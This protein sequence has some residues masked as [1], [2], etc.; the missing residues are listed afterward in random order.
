MKIDKKFLFFPA[1]HT[2]PHVANVATNGIAYN[3]LVALPTGKVW[4]LAGTYDNS[5]EMSQIYELDCGDNVENCATA[6]WVLNES[7]SLSKI[8]SGKVAMLLPSEY[9]CCE[10]DSECTPTPRITK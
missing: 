1:N 7:T 8:R 5:R 10:G 2:F 4:S 9:L 3:S 6:E